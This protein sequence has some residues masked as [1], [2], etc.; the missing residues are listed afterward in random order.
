MQEFIT[1]KVNCPCC[2]IGPQEEAL[3]LLRSLAR[4]FKKNFGKALIVNSGKRCAEHNKAV[5][6]VANSSHTKGLAFDI[7]C[8]TSREKYIVL[9]HLFRMGIQRIGV[10]KTFVHFDIDEELPQEVVWYS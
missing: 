8:P 4:D 7:S 3:V 10:Y 6:G 1:G 2:N 5:G 9:R